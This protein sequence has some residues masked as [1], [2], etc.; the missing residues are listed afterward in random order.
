MLDV[1]NIRVD[2]DSLELDYTVSSALNV[3][4]GSIGKGLYRFAQMH[5]WV[6][7]ENKNT[8]LMCIMDKTMFD[9]IRKGN[10]N[11]MK[12]S[13]NTAKI[14]EY[15]QTN[16]WRGIC[17][18]YEP[19]DKVQENEE[20]WTN[21]NDLYNHLHAANWENHVIKWKKIKSISRRLGNTENLVNCFIEGV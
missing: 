10:P 19:L 14:Q 12:V 3:T 16:D 20:I 17:A 13:N 9:Q 7:K 15:K 21:V 8:P 6:N 18:L 11:T 2:Q 1:T 5:R 4:N